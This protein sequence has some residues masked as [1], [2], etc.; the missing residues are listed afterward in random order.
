[1]SVTKTH[2]L[3]LYAAKVAVCSKV[4]TEHINII[5][6]QN[7]EFYSLNL[8]LLKVTARL[9]KVNHIFHFV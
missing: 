2:Q 8:V 5:C 1:M 3:K 4:H 7:I 9:E 6:W